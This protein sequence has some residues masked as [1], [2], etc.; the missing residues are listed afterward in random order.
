MRCMSCGA[1]IPPEFV[2]SLEINQCAG[3]GGPIYNEDTKNLLAELTEAMQKMPNDPQGV[4]GWLLSNYRFQK[5]GEGKPVDKFYRKGG[6]GIDEN[7]LKTDPSY[8]EFIKR[9][10]ATG[11][12]ARGPELA[13]KVKNAKGGKF[14]ELAEMIQEGAGDPYGETAAEPEVSVSAD[15]QRAYSELKASGFDP[16][17][18]KAGI[19][20]LSQAIR[21]QD[22][23]ELMTQGTDAPS[24]VE[25]ELSQT[26]EGRRYLDRDRHKRLKA[27]DAISGAGGS[28]R[29]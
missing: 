10:N 1:D 6:Q 26:E 25:V 22:V 15:E 21:P 11:L 3:C 13:E 23:V 28:F 12:V 5:M 24:K 4:A 29:R 19:T 20:D 7:S 8:N 14:A 27:Q 2:H 18:T 16:F 17:A 9:N